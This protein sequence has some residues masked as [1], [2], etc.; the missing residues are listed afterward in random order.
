MSCLLNICKKFTK[1][2]F[3][4]KLVKS[5]INKLHGIKGT[6]EWFLK[7]D[8]HTNLPVKTREQIWKELLEKTCHA[9][10]KEETQKF[11]EEN[12]SQLSEKGKKLALQTQLNATSIAK[13]SKKAKALKGD[14]K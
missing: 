1:D 14:K 2:K 6:F 4:H 13:S 3:N 10:F 9:R 5:T 7:C 11:A 12:T 8:T